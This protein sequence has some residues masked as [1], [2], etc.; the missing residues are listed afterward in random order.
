M[1]KH[2]TSRLLSTAL[3]AV[4][5]V[6]LTAA[7]IL[8]AGA[9]D[10]IDYINVFE[11][12]YGKHTETNE[13]V[14]NG[15]DKMKD[16]TV[17]VVT[18]NL[19]M[20]VDRVIPDSSMLVIKEGCSLNIIGGATLYCEGNLGIEYSGVINLS[21]GRLVLN[22]GGVAGV[23]GS[24]YIDQSSEVKIYSGFYVYFG[25]AVLLSGKMSAIN[26]GCVYQRDS[27]RTFGDS[28]LEGKT[29]AL[30]GYIATTK[31]LTADLDNV[32][33]IRFYDFDNKKTYRIMSAE[34]FGKIIKAW[35]KIALY[36]LWESQGIVPAIV[37]N[38]AFRLYDRDGKELAYIERPSAENDGFVCVDYMLYSYTAAGMTY[39][40]MYYYTYGV[41]E[42]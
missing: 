41:I 4:I 8:P 39:D 23:S 29:Q 20:S 13:T 12:Y 21:S 17:Y 31:R 33:Y 2:K 9:A 14:W 10:S 40:D 32:A 19:L 6:Q 26:Y 25:G 34:K 30:G 5:C 38:Y 16:N 35:N 3:A 28:K 24:L 37:H 15:F 36:P 27:I 42:H 1:K 11:D 18:D 22:S 7:L